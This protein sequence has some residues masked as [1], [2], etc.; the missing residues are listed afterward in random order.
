VESQADQGTTFTLYFPAR[1]KAETW[2]ATDGSLVPGGH[3]QK[4]LVL[5]DEPALTS[6]LK[7]T[8]AD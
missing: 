4:I 5:G 1:T 3:G 6:M 2:T 8:C 7:K